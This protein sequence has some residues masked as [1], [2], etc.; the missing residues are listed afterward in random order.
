MSAAPFLG[1][2]LEGVLAL[3]LQQGGDFFK[4]FG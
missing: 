1:A 3:E 2:D 4:D